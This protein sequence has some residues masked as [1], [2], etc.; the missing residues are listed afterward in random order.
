[1]GNA[2]TPLAD[3]F[4]VAPPGQQLTVGTYSVVLTVVGINGTKSATTGTNV[5]F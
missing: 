3:A 2:G 1:M 4:Y 5:G